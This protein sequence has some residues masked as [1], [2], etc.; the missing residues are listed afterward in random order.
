MT[1]QLQ[2]AT[3][4]AR[5]LG[6]PPTWPN[7]RTIEI[8]LISETAFSS[9]ALQEA[10]DLLIQCARTFRATERHMLRY[11]PINRFWFEDG[12]WRETFAYTEAR[13]ER[14]SKSKL[15]APAP[16]PRLEIRADDPW[17]KILGVLARRINPH[18]FETWLK[19]LRYL[20]E[21]NDVL[22]VCIPTEE[23]AHAGDKYAGLIS[24]AIDG[25][26][27]K[28]RDVK[29]VVRKAQGVAA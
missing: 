4:I 1:Q 19:P 7:L 13:A 20:G 15:P 22:Y 8:A 23:F 12:V 11:F 3:K 25:L 6:L 16:L 14:Q 27:L 29:F 10:A 21:A 18:S 5:T 28:F 24:E 26:Y 17:K 2:L 9:I